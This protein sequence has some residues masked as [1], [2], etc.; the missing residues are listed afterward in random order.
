V[1][2]NNLTVRSGGAPSSNAPLPRFTCGRCRVLFPM[3]NCLSRKLGL[4]M[5]PVQK[6]TCKWILNHPDCCN[7]QSKKWSLSAN[8]FVAKEPSTTG[9]LPRLSAIF[10][11]ISDARNILE[12]VRVARS[13]DSCE[14]HC[15]VLNPRQLYADPDTATNP[16]EDWDPTRTWVQG[17]ENTFPPGVGYQLM[18]FEEKG[19]KGEEKKGANVREKGRKRK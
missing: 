6:G 10:P 1:S 11:R 17:L 7:I 15:N 5:Q 2:G 3:Q 14:C 9:E 13:L 12:K 16:S 4:P 8:L 18:S 19:E